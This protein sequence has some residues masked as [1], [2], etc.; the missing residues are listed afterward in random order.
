MNTPL[1]PKNVTRIQAD[2][3]F[4]F[5][6]HP[7]VSCFTECCR[8]LE[9]ALTPYDCLRLRQATGLNSTE[10]LNRHVIMEQEPHETFPRFYLT[11]VDDGRASCVF[12]SP[13]GC[14]V[15]QDRPAACRTYPMGRA[16]IRQPGNRTEIFHV[17]V[18]ETHCLGFSEQQEHTAESYNQDQSLEQYNRFNDNL[19]AI[20]QHDQVRQGRQFS[21][22]Q[23]DSFTLALYDLDRFRHLLQ[24]GQLPEHKSGQITADPDQLADDEALLLWS[25]DW[26]SAVLFNN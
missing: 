15:Y 14:T 18:R 10:L 3:P 1:L 20:L 5:A 24:T 11:M 2:E 6:C 12:V 7:G 21:Q 19:I 26:L 9:L 8:E 22:E 13:D 23:I 16:A 25:M 4:T 17:L